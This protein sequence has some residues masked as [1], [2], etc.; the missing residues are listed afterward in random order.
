MHI[1]F[2]K[3]DSRNRLCST[4]SLAGKLN[5]ILLAGGL[6]ILNLSARA[7]DHMSHAEF[8]QLMRESRVR[9][10]ERFARYFQMTEKAKSKGRGG[11]ES[12]T[13]V[14][15]EPL[16]D[17]DAD[18]VNR[19]GSFTY[20]RQPPPPTPLYLETLGR[21]K[22]AIF[23]HERDLLESP[24]DASRRKNLV[25]ALIRYSKHQ[26]KLLLS[27]DA[28]HQLRRA[29]FV[30]PT[31][32]V[33]V[34]DGAVPKSFPEP[35]GK[36]TESKVKERIAQM[37]KQLFECPDDTKTRQC[38]AKWYVSYG[39]MLLRKRCADDA[40]LQYR[41]ALFVDPGNKAGVQLD[42]EYPVASPGT[43]FGEWTSPLPP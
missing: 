37:T 4:R 16:I 26:E 10:C 11:T 22:G 17:A 33:N 25:D 8:V 14:I 19:G 15:W 1:L 39:N 35:S 9:D 42:R 43:L 31:I 32:S 38:L 21:W 36:L 20:R 6:S 40:V 41:C 28:L 7:D 29:K 2:S 5:C 24:L 34:A 18:L 23:E 3:R 30:D 12:K 27:N 13:Q